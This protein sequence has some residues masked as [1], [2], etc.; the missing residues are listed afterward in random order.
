MN[1]NVN[2]NKMLENKENIPKTVLID[3]KNV[4]F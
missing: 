3:H 4:G 2:P 1:E